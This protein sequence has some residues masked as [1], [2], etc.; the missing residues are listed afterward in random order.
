MDP[1]TKIM[2]MQKGLLEP[3]ADGT[4]KSYADI[5]KVVRERF[6]MLHPAKVVFNRDQDITRGISPLIPETNE[7]PVT[8]PTAVETA[9]PSKSASF[10]KS[11]KASTIGAN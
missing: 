6:I 9:D 8:P 3:N 2:V 11:Q 4:Q 5:C 7:Q 1:E 10:Q